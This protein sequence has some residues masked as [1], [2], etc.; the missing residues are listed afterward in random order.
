MSREVKPPLSREKLVEYALAGAFNDSPLLSTGHDVVCP[1]CGRRHSVVLLKYL[2]AE[3]FEVGPTEQVDV[4]NPEGIMFFMEKETYTPVIFR[5]ACEDCGGT[6][7]VKLSA[8]YLLKIA[9][10]PQAAK[11]LYA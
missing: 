11:S 10:R 2:K 6:S 1:G 5:P 9:E 4:V 7:E 3:T 8:E